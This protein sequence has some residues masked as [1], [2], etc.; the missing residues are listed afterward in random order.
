MPKRGGKQ[1]GG[2]GGRGG[3]RGGGHSNRP[4]GNKSGGGGGRGGGRGGYGGKQFDYQYDSDDDQL[5]FVGRNH[6]QRQRATEEEIYRRIQ[7]AKGDR[8]SASPSG[9]RGGGRGGGSGGGFRP[10]PPPKQNGNGKSSKH[11]FWP[12]P[13]DNNQSSS[14]GNHHQSQSSNAIRRSG[15]APNHV[16]V[17]F[18]RATAVSDRSLRQNHDEDELD[19][20]EDS[21]DDSSDDDKTDHGSDSDED[22]EDEILMNQFDWIEEDQQQERSTATTTTTTT[23]AT[24]QRLQGQGPS[25]TKKHNNNNSNGQTQ[26]QNIVDLVSASFHSLT[27]S[28]PDHAMTQSEDFIQAM[29]GQGDLRV[30]ADKITDLAR[31]SSVLS[32]IS[33]HTITTSTT[34]TTTSSSSIVGMNA[35]T[36]EFGGMGLASQEAGIATGKEEAML[37]VMDA[38]PTP[39]VMIVTQTEQTMELLVDESALVLPE[40]PKKKAHRSKRGGRRNQ[41]EKRMNSQFVVG[42]DDDGPM[43]LEEPSD[44]EDEERLALEDYLQNTMGSDNSDQFDSLLDSLNG[45][46]NGGQGH[47]KSV[48]GKHAD[49]SDYEQQVSEI[50]SDDY[51][52]DEFDFEEDYE[53][54][55][56]KLDFSKVK[57][58]M[59]DKRK[60]RAADDLL[61]EELR[62]LMP[63]WRSG[64][65]EN[66]D[67]SHRPFKARAKGYAFYDSDDEFL[68]GAGGGGGG[69]K[70]KKNKKE[71]HGGSF[72]TLMDINR[73]IEDFVKD[74]HNDSLQLAPMPK[75]LRRKVH[76]LCNHY[77]LK[78][79]SV[80]SGKRR[81]PI[82]IKTDRTKMPL[83]PVNVNKLLN[84]SEKELTMLSAQF[85]GSRKGGNSYNNY[86]NNNF[87]GKGG[88]KGGNNNNNNGGFMKG[89]GKNG[90]GGGSMAAPHGTVVGASASAISVENVG[91]KMLSK[92]G[93]MPGV[94]LGAS[95]EGITQPIEAIVRAKNRGLG[96]E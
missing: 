41:R 83:N 17:Q 42:H 5:N 3:G 7:A 85:Q 79:Q 16:Q 18:S 47:S 52:E 38:A 10:P 28:T 39:D 73:Q 72:E 32:S 57:A 53:D 96:H 61:R 59:N 74:R 12:Y 27:I 81:F 4:R 44:E 23:T 70:N 14:G 66:G 87:G 50:D 64:A 55:I 15:R 56:K 19:S 90:G 94:G 58:S 63:L 65:L 69:G 78:S 46:H 88:K 37:W 30:D 67:G 54:G 25:S 8:S 93:W 95:G 84:Q 75:P 43:Y 77:S 9:G 24:Q 13:E 21:E 2:G 68:T 20:D 82:L 33:S 92:M 76:L 49:D 1:G 51:E 34:T 36:D 45:L 11:F 29:E 48:G 86:N 71:P 80:G 60:N 40:K 26:R 22:S 31:P 91:H 35:D 62:D 89:K 6:Q